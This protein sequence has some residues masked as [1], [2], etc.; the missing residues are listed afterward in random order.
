[1]REFNELRE[2]PRFYNTLTTHCTTMILAHSAANPGLL[3]YSW[4]VLASGYSPE[5]A[6]ENG[7]LDRSPPFEALKERSHINAAA[8]AADR[9]PNFSRR[10][11]AGLP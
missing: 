6:Y 5:Y 2:P 9:A 10:I 7:R 11:R 4:K 3:A 1:M 8:R